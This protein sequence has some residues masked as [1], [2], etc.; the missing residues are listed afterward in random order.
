MKTTQTV[1]CAMV[2]STILVG[3]VFASG[4]TGSNIFGFFDSAINAVVM[5]L[6]PGDPCEGRICTNCHPGSGGSEGN[7][8]CRPNDN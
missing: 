2:L 7:G 5:M 4:F 8:N 6:R 1:L 3:N